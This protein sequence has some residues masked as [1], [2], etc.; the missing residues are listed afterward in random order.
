MGF[1]YIMAGF[2]LLFNPIIH[3]IDLLPDFIGFFLI[4]KGLSKLSYLNSGLSEARDIF[5]KLGFAELIRVACI[6]FIPYTSDSAMLLFAF[7]FGVIELIYFIPALNYFYE[8]L[9]YIGMQYDG[10]SVFAKIEKKKRGRRKKGETGEVTRVIET[11]AALKR[12]TYSF[13][14]LRIICTLLPELTALQMYD[15]LGTVTAFSIN[16]SRY[17]PFM[18]VV[19]GLI[20]VIVGIR[21][22]TKLVKYFTG[23]QK[24][25]Q[26][27]DTL[28][29]KYDRDI[30]VKTEIFM[31]KSMKNA[32][33]LYIGA[34]VLSLCLYID[35]INVILG[36]FSSIFLAASVII[37]GKYTKIAY[38]VIPFCVI[39]SV[40]SVINMIL[41]KIYYID[42]IYDETA[43]E[44]YAEAH[45]QYYRMGT[46]MTIENIVAAVSFVIFAVALLKTVK[47]HLAE[48]GIQDQ[49]VRYSKASRDIEVYNAVGAKLLMNLV[50]MLINF[51]L[52]ASYLFIMLN[53]TAIVAINTA[54]TIIWIFHS[55]STVSTINELLYNPL[56]NEE[57]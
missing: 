27:I 11:G 39:R 5:R 51:I 42:N 33:F 7:V 41:Q 35:G 53:L 57:I 54:V 44:W 21:W 48:S 38:A 43:V 50:L 55:I 22:I 45:D 49:N 6:V 24:D 14:I 3:V 15:N 32:L 26:F 30:A 17:K 31:G 37:I 47:T 1:G 4:C 19:L 52:A 10:E 40:L 16:Y 56:I 23:I 9:N 36:A 8:G 34:V 25:K 18:Y 20:V 2:I 12:L 28:N 29:T 13:Y 46:L